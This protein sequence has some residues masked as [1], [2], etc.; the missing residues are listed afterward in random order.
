MKKL[1]ILFVL[2]L[3]TFHLYAESVNI[4]FFLQTGEILE[5]EINA[6]TRL[7]Q[8]NDNF[9]P[10]SKLYDDFLIV[11]IEGLEDLYNKPKIWT[12]NSKNSEFAVL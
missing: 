11:D 5:K 8:I 2:I 3:S 6:N 9:F 1:I 10:E 4:K 7:L 12:K